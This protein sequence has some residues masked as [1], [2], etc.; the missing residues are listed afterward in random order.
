MTVCLVVMGRHIPQLSF[1]SVVL[2]EDHPLT[3]GEDCYQRLLR[4]GPSDEAE[5]AHAYLKDHPPA[6]LY[7]D[8][9]VPTLVAIEADHSEGAIDRE[10]RDRMMEAVSDLLDDVSE[11]IPA[12]NPDPAAPLVRVIP[13]RA[14]RDHSAAR[15]AAHALALRGLRT[16]TLPVLSSMA[17]AVDTLRDEAPAAIVLSV[18]TPS[19]P[20]HARRVCT[21]VRRLLPSCRIL[22]GLW[23]RADE[24]LDAD[25]AQLL[26]AGA[27]TVVVSITQLCESLAPSGDASP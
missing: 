1:L 27:D 7:D 15:M 9:L 20:S 22:I 10:H 18:T 5:L 25:K 11:H 13:V 23:D 6:S 19:R 8:M 24:D 16:A 21:N 3:P 4:Q 14:E 12:G 17:D 2:G 26:A